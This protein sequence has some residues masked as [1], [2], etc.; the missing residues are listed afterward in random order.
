MMLLSLGYIYREQR[1]LDNAIVHA[2]Q[3]YT[4]YKAFLTP[5]KVGG[6]SLEFD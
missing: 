4:I 6:E 5:T 3:A 1:R 2:E